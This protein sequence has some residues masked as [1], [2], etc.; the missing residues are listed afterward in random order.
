[1]KLENNI[2]DEEKQ[3]RWRTTVIWRTAVKLEN[4]C[5]ARDQQ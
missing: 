3:Q 2:K 5:K 4:N 1:V